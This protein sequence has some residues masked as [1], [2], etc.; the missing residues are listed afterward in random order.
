MLDF[1]IVSD[2]VVGVGESNVL[3]IGL[4]VAEIK[5]A[6]VQG[7]KYGEVSTF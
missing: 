7:D 1:I 3:S 5:I 4:C 6:A 2:E